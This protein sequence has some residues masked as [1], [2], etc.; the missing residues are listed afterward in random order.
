MAY[1]RGKLCCASMEAYVRVSYSCVLPAAD[2][3]ELC[4][5][6][7][8]CPVWRDMSSQTTCWSYERLPFG[9][10]GEVPRVRSNSFQVFRRPIMT[11]TPRVRRPP[12]P[13]PD[14]NASIKSPPR[15][16][17]LCTPCSV[18]TTC[19]GHC[20]LQA[21]PIPRVN[22]LTG[23]CALASRRRGGRPLI[24]PPFD[25]STPSRKPPTR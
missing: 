14:T 7:V 8:L 24:P 17:D 10:A 22:G 19:R 25:I 16:T 23:A 2:A 9:P 11:I 3:S 15:R 21:A 6:V 1:F 5:V 20:H 4:L 13:P 18:H 12:P